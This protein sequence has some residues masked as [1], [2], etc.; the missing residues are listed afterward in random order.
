MTPS[1]PVHRNWF[2]AAG[3]VT[4]VDD[5]FAWADLPSGI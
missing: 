1:G 2:S 3:R 5:V 4:T